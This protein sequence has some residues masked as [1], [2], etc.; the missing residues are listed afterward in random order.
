VK[1]AFLALVAEARIPMGQPA[2]RRFDM[3]SRR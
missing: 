2:S 1:G 3:K